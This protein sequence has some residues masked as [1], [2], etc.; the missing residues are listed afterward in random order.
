MKKKSLPIILIICLILPVIFN[1]LYGCSPHY[2]IF[3]PPDFIPTKAP[4]DWLTIGPSTKSYKS[5]KSI[6]LDKVPA[7]HIDLP[8]NRIPDYIMP[9]SDG[10][11]LAVSQISLDDDEKTGVQLYSLQAIRFKAD[12]TVLWEK[13]YESIIYQGY[14][15]SMC[16]FPDDGFAV[17]MNVDIKNSGTYTTLDR[18]YRFSSNGTLLW[19]ISDTVAAD[20]A[21]DHLFAMKDGTLIAAGS[22]DLRNLDG[23]FRDNNIGLFHFEKD[24]TL[25]KQKVFGTQG[26]DNLIAASKAEASDIILF[27]KSQSESG[28]DTGMESKLEC[29]NED[30]DSRWVYKAGKNE[31]LFDVITLPDGKGALAFSSLIE[32]QNSNTGF[33][34]VPMMLHFDNNG[35]KTWTYT[36]GVGQKAWMKTAAILKDGRIVAGWFNNVSSDLGQESNLELFSET[37]TLIDSI[38]KMPGVIQQIIPTKDGGFTVISSQIVSGLPQPPYV[39]SIWQDSE[40]IVAHYDKKLRITWQRSI[41]QYK[42]ELR[43]DIVIPTADDRLLVG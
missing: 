21:L 42:H 32:S 14:P 34:T 27:W 8:K 37:G 1:S 35:K 19:E 36:A 31:N 33:S 10:G 30:L 13:K 7:T 2:D 41:D 43:S 17:S 12:G 28:I 39:S 20:V 18:L 24:G 15:K 26:N 6:A 23:S 38:S 16:V 22:V 29:F 9:I 11:C 4:K 40:K 3:N 25:S 5:I